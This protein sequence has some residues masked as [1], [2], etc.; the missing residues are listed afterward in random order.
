MSQIICRIFIL[1][2]TQHADELQRW[3]LRSIRKRSPEEE[4][5]KK[6]N[7]LDYKVGAYWDTGTTVDCWTVE[8][9]WIAG[10]STRFTSH[11]LIRK[12]SLEEENYYEV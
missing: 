1:T 2:D 6:D 12:L 11:A 3:S 4:G 7:L 8:A 9:Y 10:A 5:K